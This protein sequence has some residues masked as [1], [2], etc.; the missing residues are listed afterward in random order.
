MNWRSFQNKIT[1]IENI[2]DTSLKNKNHYAHVYRS[3]KSLEIVLWLFQNFS[4]D[5]FKLENSNL[6]QH[7][8]WLKI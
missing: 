7:F 5:T 6:E 1:T 3:N 8:G 4:A 2:E